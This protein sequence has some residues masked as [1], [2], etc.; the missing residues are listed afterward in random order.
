[1]HCELH[2]HRKHGIN[3]HLLHYKYQAVHFMQISS[4]N[5]PVNSNLGW[6]TSL[7]VYV[8]LLPWLSVS[9]AVRVAGVDAI[10]RGNEF[11][12]LKF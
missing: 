3:R 11:S 12:Q 5:K 8:P 7:P 1:M 6:E 2:R 9:R 4:M 10:E